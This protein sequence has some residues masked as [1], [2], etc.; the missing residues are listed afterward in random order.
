[1]ISADISIF[2]Q[3]SATFITQ[4]NTDKDCISIHS[5]FSWVL[6]GLFNKHGC[7]FDDVIKI[8]F[9]RAT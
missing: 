6:K 4:I 9:V 3:K 5:N 1:M 7:N 8:G 2:Q